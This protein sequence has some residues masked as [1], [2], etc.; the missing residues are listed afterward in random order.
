MVNRKFNGVDIG[1]SAVE[2]F[3]KLAKLES[4]GRYDLADQKSYIGKYQIGTDVLGDM[5]WVQKGSKWS[6]VRF[7]GEA[8]TKWKLT[9][10][11]SFLNNPA[12]QDEVIMRSVKM[13][14]ATLKKHT[15]KICK[16]ITVPKNAVY[17]APGKKTASETKVKTIIMKKK[18]QGYKAEDLRGKSFLLTSSG[19]LAASHLCGQGAMSNALEN[20]FKG[21]WGIPVDGNAM[22]SLLYAENLAGHDLSVIIGYK[23]NC[24]ID[25]KVVEKNDTQIDNKNINKQAIIQKNTK[26]NTPA[27]SSQNSTSTENNKSGVFEFTGQKFQEVLE[28]EEYKRIRTENGNAPELAFVNPEEAILKRLQA[29][30]QDENVYNEDYAKYLETKTGKKVLEENKEDINVILKMYDEITKDNNKIGNVI[31][32]HGFDVLRGREESNEILRIQDI[33]YY[34]YSYPIPNKSAIESLEYVLSQYSAKYVKYP[35]KKPVNKFKKQK[36]YVDKIQGVIQ[37]HVKG[38]ETKIEKDQLP[39]RYDKYMQGIKDIDEIVIKVAKKPSSELQKT[40]CENLIRELGKNTAE[41]EK[42]YSINENGVRQFPLSR[43]LIDNIIIEFIKVQTG[44][45]EENETKYFDNHK[46]K[47]SNIVRNYLLWYIK[48]YKG[49]DFETGLFGRLE[50][51]GKDIRVTTVLNDWITSKSAIKVQNIKKISDLIDEVYENYRDNIDFKKDKNIILNLFK[52]SK[53]LRDY[54]SNV[55]SMDLYSFYKSF[56]DLQNIINPT[57]ELFVNNNCILKCTLGKETSKLIINGDSVTLGGGKQANINDTNIQPF[58]SCSAIGICQPALMGMWEKNTDVKVRNKPALLDIST[59]QCQYGGTISI[60]DAGQKKM[61]TAVTKTMELS[62]ITREADCQ[63]KLLI[64]ICRDINNNFM[65]IQLKKEAQNFSKWKKYKDEIKDK[66][67]SYFSKDVKKG[68]ETDKV[69]ILK[70]ENYEN[71]IRVNKTKMKIAEAEISSKKEKNLREKIFSV[72]QEAHKMVKQ[73]SEPNLDTKGII[74]N[75]GSSLC[76]HEKKHFYSA[77]MLP[78]IV[79]GYLMQSGNLAINEE[80]EKA[81]EMELNNV[82]GNTKMREIKLHNYTIQNNIKR[83]QETKTNRIESSDIVNWIEIGKYLCMNE[84]DTLNETEILK[85]IREKGKNIATCPFSTAEWN[86]VHNQSKLSVPE[87]KSPVVNDNQNKNEKNKKTENE[88]KNIDEILNKNNENSNKNQPSTQNID[89][90]TQISNKTEC[91]IDNCPHKNTKKEAP[92]VKIAEEEMKKYKG[93]KESSRDLYNRIQKKYFPDANFGTDKNPSKV[94]WCAAFV[95]YCMKTA[96]YKNSSNPSVGGY[97]WGVA[98]RPGL[99]KRG[100]F[101]G[102]KTEPFTGAIGIFKFRGGYSHVAILVG[103][104]KNGMLVF[105]GGNQNNEINKTAYEPSRIDYFMKPKNYT[106]SSEEKELPIITESQNAGSI[107]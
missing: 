36:D 69:S 50:K 54:A 55:D 106:V 94:A 92:W 70:K 42:T 10:K 88:T 58:K 73:K 44:F 79:Y 89:K 96:G 16:N 31:R 95:T 72:F 46:Y 53:E 98:P 12:A 28:S 91:K 71:F 81:I 104:R 87:T 13:R 9:D 105:L 11:R 100:W 86:T 93:Q 47:D 5:G 61:G 19:M 43:R 99:P 3:E 51:I 60:D 14:W 27:N 4:N 52:N 33:I 107:G 35:D 57:G 49:I 30:F 77:K 24:Q 32:Q 1:D 65:Q 6:N 85:K 97:D 18:A 23:D 21:V 75:H 37:I 17:K 102:E 67:T 84:K 25:N 66:I 76:D 22:P 62:E 45:K 83:I 56:Y 20:N 80:E 40:R 78:A 34:I 7:I 68:F 103:K 48:K 26:G 59:I 29:K 2:F 74:K 82:K 8:A 39:E 101:E 90:N 15:D 41:Y 63:Y 64:N 38:E